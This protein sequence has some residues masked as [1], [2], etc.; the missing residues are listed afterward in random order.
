MNERASGNEYHGSEV[1]V[2]G[3]ACRLP[4][5]R[6]VEEF[7]RNLCDGVE[8]ITFFDD[9]ELEAAGVDRA[10]LD[11]PHYVKAAPILDDVELF[12]ASFF[13]YTPRE[14]EVMDPQQRLFLECAWEALEHSGYGAGLG[15]GSIGVFAGGKM[16]TYIFN[17][18]SNPERMRSLDT[19][20]I[21]LGNDIALLSMR[22]SYKLDLDGP[23]YF[24]QSACSTSLVA[25][26]LACQSLLTDECRMA[27]AG[28]VAIDVPHKRGYRYQEGSLN[29]PDGHVRAFD[30]KAQGTIFG[31]GLGAVVL[32]RLE[33]AVADGDRIYAVIKGSATNND[34]AAKANFTAPSVDG[35]ARVIL[36][37]LVN[38]EVRP[39]T[40]SYV[41]AHG[42]GT[43]LGDPIEI[44]AL[45]KAFRAGT[46]E[47]AF[48]ALGSVKTNLGHLDAAAGVSALI[49]T[50]L[51]LDRRRLPP[52]LH[53]EEPNPK[54]EFAGSPF[55]V[56]TALAPWSDESGPRRA[57]VSSFGFGGTNSHVVLEQAPPARASGESRPRQLLILSAKSE[58]ALEAA[59]DRLRDHLAEH[60]DLDLADVAYTLKL[61]R[62]AFR[63]RRAV[64]AAS[65][66]EAA[67]I[68]EERDPQQVFTRFQKSAETPV[69]FLF[70][71]QGAQ[72]V[73][74][75][76]ELYLG[77]PTFRDQVDRCAEILGPHLGLDLRTLLYPPEDQ[78]AEAALRLG[79]TAVAQPALFVVEVALARLWSEWGVRPQAMIGHS[80]GEYVAACLAEVFSLEDALALVAARG[81]LMQEMPAGAMLSVALAEEEV[82]PLLG[83]ELSL[84]AVNGPGRCVVSGPADAVDALAR[85]LVD[86]GVQHRSLHTSHAFHSAMMD[87]VLEPFLEA[88][89]KVRRNP[90]KI[91][92]ISNLTGGWISDEAATD[93]HYWVEHLRK[94]VRFSEGLGELLREPERVLLEVG[95]GN[96]LHTFARE[97]PIRS[98]D[99]AVVHSLPHPNDQ[100]SD[101]AF[102]LTAAG[103]LWLAGVEIDGTGLYAHERRHRLP[104]PSYPF[105]RRRYWIDPGEGTVAAQPGADK[106]RKQPDVADWF[107]F[108]SWKRSV[109]PEAAEAEAGSDRRPWVVLADELG[110]GTRLVERLQQ[111]G[112]DAVTVR[113]GEGFQRQGDGSYT[114]HAERPEDYDA[115]FRELHSLDRDPGVIVHLWTLTS[116]APGDPGVTSFD[117]MQERGFYSLIYLARALGNQDTADKLRI[118][119]IS[120][121]LHEVIGGEALS[122]EKATV[123]GPCKVIPQ[124]YPN[125]TCRSID[126]EVPEPGTPHEAELVDRLIAE[127]ASSPEEPMV[128]YRGLHRWVRT[129]EKRKLGDGTQPPG[130]LRRGGVYLITGGLGGIGLVLA[131]YLAR[132]VGARLVLVGRSPMP[133]RGEWEAWL[134]SHEQQDAT[135]RK[136]RSIQELEASGAEVLPASADVADGEQMRQVLTTARERFGVLHGVVHAAGIAGGGLIQLKTPEEVAKVFRP[137]VLG[138][139]ALDALL[140]EEDLDFLVLF[141]SISSVLGEFGQVD[142]CAANLFLDA[143]AHRRH[144]ERGTFTVAVNWDTWQEV[145]IAVSTEVPEEMRQL[146]DEAIRLG[147]SN[148]EGQEAFGRILA[149]SAG[150]QVIVCTRDLET[151]IDQVKEFTQSQI[152]AA[153]GIG[154]AAGPKHP[155]PQLET[156]YAAPASATEQTV[157]DLWQ[158]V[159]GIEQVGR[160]DNFF[161][162]G[163]HSL[164]ATQLMSRLRGALHIELPVERLFEAPT[165]AGLTEHIETVRW[166]ARGQE[167][168]TGVAAADRDEGEL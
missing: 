14:A 42:T 97:H 11:D 139:L 161:D 140:A 50:V 12:D 64:V 125:L 6:N 29:S 83:E 30:A 98:T 114:V 116:K 87:P 49:K 111:T 26:H 148:L 7:W 90:P 106:L 18:Y 155:R 159:L 70:S 102:L 47:V 157:A 61:G 77:E 78:A 4:K 73:N 107:Y 79:Q 74:M 40:I 82:R 144:A 28:A 36:E 67:R 124:E 55:Y 143:W 24:V 89:R 85:Q 127:I 104:L 136:I 48:C 17:I 86:K 150:A 53:F 66:E 21:G 19:L 152:L 119:V 151:A 168:L 10:E 166:A 132:T 108:P 5:A 75:A 141:S 60:P 117:R 100:R 1:A 32:K 43:H 35:E 91:P 76:R 134:E 120:D 137:K 15:E 16:S 38:A 112:R 122:P 62:R 20:E 133:E 153:T 54:I 165:V 142:Y 162:L 145:G 160:N 80:I 123:L 109:K 56:N 57:G 130:R 101:L 121:H 138:L 163:G 129:Y 99:Q 23:S 88:V 118:E 147:I 158:E 25:V 31:S 59:T 8:A 63:H 33:D 45:T 146:R 95:P 13:D 58:S 126:V 93:P 69:V 149:E 115:L 51:A 154:Q 68:L 9:E 3:M 72:Y 94:T 164:L 105:E 103:R 167:G 37:A 113:A 2:I 52:S 34:G 92:F 110:V 156:D 22:A 44:R 84:A 39:E 46:E 27:L 128:A 65:C 71:G 131:Q 135:S 96:A 41:E 81:R